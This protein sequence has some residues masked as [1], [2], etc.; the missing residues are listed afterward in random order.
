[1]I[2]K[3]TN[4]WVVVKGDNKPFAYTCHRDETQSI[5]EALRFTSYTWRELE[6]QGYRCIN[7][8]ITFEEV[9]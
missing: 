9:K 5:D 2:R 6:A 3:L 8:N 7:V 4:Y 1:M